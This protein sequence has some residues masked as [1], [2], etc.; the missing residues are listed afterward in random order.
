MIF[1]VLL[2]CRLRISFV[3]VSLFA[4]MVAVACEWFLLIFFFVI[5]RTYSHAHNFS[6]VHRSSQS[7]P[8][9]EQRDPE[10]C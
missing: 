5:L 10:G 4:P 8:V 9:K 1:L 7:I 6:L 2:F 3:Y